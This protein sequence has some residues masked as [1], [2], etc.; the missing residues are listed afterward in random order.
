M[1]KSKTLN[2]VQVLRGIASLL[3]VIMHATIAGKEIFSINLLGGIFSFGGA[4]VDIFFVLSGFIITY[5]SSKNLGNHKKF[6]SFLKRR[7]IRIFPIYWI[8]ITGFLIIQLLLPSFYKTPFTLTLSNFLHTYL[9][10]PDHEMI[11]GVSWTL[12]YE[13]FFYL[14]FSLAFIIKHKTVLWALALLYIGSIIAAEFI[15]P[16]NPHANAWMRMLF[17]PMNIEFFMGILAAK[18]I[19]K[20]EAKY[21]WPLILAGCS[22]F[23][24]FGVLSN[25]GFT[26][27]NSVFNRVIMFGIPAFLI[28]TGV[29][30]LEVKKHIKPHNI[31][32]SLGSASYSLYLIHLPL[33]VAALKILHRFSFVNNIFLQV[34][35]IGLILIICAFSILFFNRVEAPLIKRLSVKL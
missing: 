23:I 12:S 22:F 24:V 19:S 2:L 15:F 35:I 3:V 10:L 1:E 27:L 30:V 14:L 5:T 26:F 8:I 33:L 32:M 29:V 25:Q 34:A 31:F 7:F 9:L 4:G 18:L 28:I 17:Y 6:L 21:A 20:L 16:L 13:L 11:N